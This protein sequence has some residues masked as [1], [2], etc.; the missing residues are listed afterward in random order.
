MNTNIL[1]TA[2]AGSADRFFFY[3]QIDVRTQAEADLSE[4]LMQGQGALFY[5]RSYGADMA[6]RENYPNGMTFQIKAAA[7]IVNSVA[8]RNMRVTSGA[9]GYPD[10]RIIVSQGS[11]DFTQKSEAVDVQVGYILM[12]DVAALRRQGTP[13]GIR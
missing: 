12:V 2:Q 6:S 8:K 5:N 4:L 11:I 1:T 9:G 7:D 3:D 13:G 10:R